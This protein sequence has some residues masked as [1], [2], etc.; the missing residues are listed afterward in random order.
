MGLITH[1]N[2]HTPEEKVNSHS[3]CLKF[4]WVE[5]KPLSRVWRFELGA[6]P[7]E[8]NCVDLRS[9]GIAQ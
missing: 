2:L 9:I 5:K 8:G 1:C 7:R 3:P 6:T 4:E